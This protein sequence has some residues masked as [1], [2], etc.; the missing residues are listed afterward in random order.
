MND[1]LSIV[2]DFLQ[3]RMDL[4]PA[5]V[6]PEATLEELGVDSLMLL[7]LMFEFEE[8]LNTPLPQDLPPPKT[9]GELLAKRPERVIET[10]VRGM[11]PKTTLGRNQLG[12]LKVYA[13]SEHPHTAQQPKAFEITQVAQ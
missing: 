9:V 7:E 2:R 3:D 10:A 11:L 12:K 6:T 13:G 5:R 8:K 1:L 4:D